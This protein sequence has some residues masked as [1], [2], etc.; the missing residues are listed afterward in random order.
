MIIFCITHSFT[1]QIM[2]F[3]YINT[4]VHGLDLVKHFMK[5]RE[6]VFHVLQGMLVPNAFK[7]KM[8]F[9]HGLMM[10]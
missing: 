7:N 10:R 3:T 6:F 2:S 9:T 5:F 1:K 4:N 8:F